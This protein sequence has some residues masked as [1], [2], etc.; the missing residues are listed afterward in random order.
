MRY[1]ETA[2]NSIIEIYKSREIE[3]QNLAVLTALKLGDKSY[4]DF[5]LKQQYAGAGAMHI[6]AVSGLHVGIVFLL[7]NFL[8]LL[9][10]PNHL[11][12][13][14]FQLSYSA[15]IG[16]VLMHPPIYKLLYFK[17]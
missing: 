11:F 5:E 6:L 1:A 15:V 8:L 14:G 12:Q 3:N 10:D 17:T 2:R 16:I 9:I 13:V 7:F 4:L